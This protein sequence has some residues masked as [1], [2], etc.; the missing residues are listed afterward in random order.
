[1]I[2]SQY[3]VWIMVFLQSNRHIMFSLNPD[4]VTTL[5]L[6]IANPDES[7]QSVDV[8]IYIPD[9]YRKLFYFKQSELDEFESG[10]RTCLNTYS[11]EV[12]EH[13]N[14]LDDDQVLLFD[15]EPLIGKWIITAHATSSGF[16]NTSGDLLP[17]DNPLFTY[18]YMPEGIDDKSIATRY[19]HLVET[20][21]YFDNLPQ[22][23]D[24]IQ[25]LR[26]NPKSCL[27]I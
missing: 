12:T 5:R 9:R 11:L 17:I 27:F 16:I 3:A 15:T 7:S 8:D 18:A 21:C 23:F 25:G 1:M 19:R 10:T 24:L 22:A 6:N 13:K 26:S 4:I 2:A 20:G 14:R